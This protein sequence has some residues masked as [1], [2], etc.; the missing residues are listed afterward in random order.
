MR[1]ELVGS[2]KDNDADRK[3]LNDLGLALT[4]ALENYQSWY[5]KEEGYFRGDPGFF[6]RLR[7]G[8]SGQKQAQE[9]ITSVLKEEDS[10]HAET[11]VNAFL[12][13][14]KT[15][16]D[17]HSFASFLLDELKKIEDSRWSEID[18]DPKS[19]CYDKPAVID[20]LERPPSV[21]LSPSLRI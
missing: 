13:A 19:R 6:S 1:S 21:S 4:T 12:S 14:A 11:L 17:R 20:C 16:Y 3:F 7:H 10:F 5:N 2:D 8:K 9:F 18:C 15:P